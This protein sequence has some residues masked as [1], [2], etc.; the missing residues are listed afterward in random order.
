MNEIETQVQEQ[1]Q[2][3]SVQEAL[4]EQATVVRVTLVSAIREIASRP[5]Y[6][7]AGWSVVNHAE[8]QELDALIGARVRSTKT[9][10]RQVFRSL[11]VP[12]CQGS[13]SVA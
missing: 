9:A 8:D 4:Q 2:V 7:K 10:A 5:R 6:I 3:E 1:P 13:V 12:S 11:V